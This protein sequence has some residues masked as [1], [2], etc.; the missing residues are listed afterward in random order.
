MVWLQGTVVRKAVGYVDRYG[1][2]VSLCFD[3]SELAI[4]RFDGR[5]RYLSS[6]DLDPI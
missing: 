3:L 5:R 6:L 4:A 1:S 2:Q